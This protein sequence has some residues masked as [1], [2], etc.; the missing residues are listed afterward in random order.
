MVV[1]ILVLLSQF[2]PP[3]LCPQVC[4]LCLGLC[5]CSANRFISTI[6]LDSIYI[7]INILYLW[8]YHSSTL[9]WKIPQTEVPGRLLSIG[10]QWVGHNW[11][12]LACTHA[13]WT[14]LISS[15]CLSYKSIYMWSP[16]LYIY[17]Y[18][19]TFR[20]HLDN[21]KFSPHLK[22]I[23]STTSGKIFFTDEITFIGSGDWH[24]Y[25]PRSH[26][27]AYH[28]GYIL[29]QR[30]ATGRDRVWTKPNLTL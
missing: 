21:T 14:H 8:S 11:N 24:G 22:I 17:I 26:F 12:D 15:A 20:A 23:T 3:S 5:S 25:C 27:L 19:I 30:C 7:C 1:C 10:S 13:S 29:V 28:R 16:I 2:D 4:S 6:F 18:V 9:A